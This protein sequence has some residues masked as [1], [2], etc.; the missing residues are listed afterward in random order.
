MDSGLG[1]WTHRQLQVLPDALL[2]ASE[3]GPCDGVQQGG[4]AGQARSLR[5]S[6]V[7]M[8]MALRLAITVDL[9]PLMMR[10]LRLANMRPLKRKRKDSLGCNGSDR[11]TASRC[12]DQWRVAS[13]TAMDGRRGALDDVF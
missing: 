10:A 12:P 13:G 1:S 8:R 3:F 7:S 2:P 6:S 11:S 4:G 5:D 9:H